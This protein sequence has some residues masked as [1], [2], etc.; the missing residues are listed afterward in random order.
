MAPLDC[1]AN[2]DG[3][4]ETALLG[5]AA[6]VVAAAAGAPVVVHSADRVPA[7]QG[8]TYKHVLDA[9]GVPTD[10]EPE[11][12]AAMVDEVG[13]GFYYQPRFNPR[14]HD[15]LD[16]REALGVRSYLNTVETLANPANAP[17]HLGSFFHR[18]FPEKILETVRKSRTVGFKRIVMVRGLE[19]YDDARPR[20]TTIVEYRDGDVHDFEVDAGS[21]DLTVETADLR[22]ANVARDSA[23][24]TEA[25]IRG[26]RDGAHTDAVTL[27]AGIRLYA[28]GVAESVDAG[29]DRASAAIDDGR[30]EVV[31]DRLRSFDGGREQDPVVVDET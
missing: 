5:V 16:R 10:V 2:Y 28:A 17:A 13:F 25:V 27:N 24:L 7:S 30:A 18:S 26:D 29:V 23:G 19:G 12:S 15:L 11:T 1:G 31:L 3:K 9:L 14:V 20:R 4:R 21:L 8:V 22:V 6:G